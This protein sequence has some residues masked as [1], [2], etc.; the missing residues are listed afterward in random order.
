[1][2]TLR[3]LSHVSAASLSLIGF[4]VG[5][6][7]ATTV[8]DSSGATGAVAGVGGTGNVGVG[9]NGAPT[10]GQGPGAGGG[11]IVPGAG[12]G[13]VLPPNGECVPGIPATSQIPRLRNREYDGAIKELLGL[14]T[15]SNGALPSAALN[16]DYDGSLNKNS[17]G[18]YQDA[19]DKIAVDVM[20][21]PTAKAK[22]VSCDASQPSCLE[23]SIREFGRKAFRRKVTDAEV[24]SLMRLNS[25]T[26]APTSQD[27]V[28]EAMLY[29]FLVSPSFI[30]LP[31][32]AQDVEG[33]AIKLNNDEVASR[34]AILLWGSIPDET[35][36]TAADDGLLSTKEQILEQAKR[37]VGERDLAAPLVQAFHRAYLDMDGPRW[38]KAGHDA[39]MYPLWS[40]AVMAPALAEVGAFVEE[41][42]FNNGK[43]SDLF[44]SNTGFVNKDTAPIYGLDAASYGTEL[45]K[46][47]LTPPEQRPGILTRVGFLSSYS[48]Y[49]TSSIILRG[50]FVIG[51]I[52]G[53]DPGPPS[54]GATETEIPPGDYKTYRESIEALI[55]TGAPCTECHSTYVNPTGYVLEKYNSIGEWQ[56]VDK[57]GGDIDGTGNVM[58]QK[59][60]K[61]GTVPEIVKLISSPQELMTELANGPTA[62]RHYAEKWVSFVTGR[63]PNGNDACTVDVLNTNLQGDSYTVL[64]LMTDLTQA[65]SFRL[66]T[67]GN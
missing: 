33:S 42:T 67:V 38:G 39:T 23:T 28:V 22:F 6:G 4:I 21:N 54:E 20:A 66:R 13:V 48:K 37:M 5:C 52:Q 19:A 36:R 3:H 25:L 55:A 46:V 50:A 60:S 43:F 10:G 45:T 51:H 47:S 16:A 40:D 63:I 35:L 34:L 15:L 30:M 49:N 8:D 12:G 41:V 14:T 26:P 17:W 32:L 58:L 9:G 65:D 64:N 7:P 44:L 61:D 18:A 1:M 56:T 24:T 57:L 59:A 31:E 29:A 62:K 2:R 11:G 27:E 53:I